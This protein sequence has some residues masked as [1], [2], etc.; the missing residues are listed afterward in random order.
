MDIFQ[1]VER[2]ADIVATLQKFSKCTRIREESLCFVSMATANEKRRQD[3]S[4]CVPFL[5]RVVEEIQAL[6][7]KFDSNY[8]ES[9]ESRRNYIAT[10]KQEELPEENLFCNERKELL[11]KLENYNQALSHKLSI[12]HLNRAETLK[13]ISMLHQPGKT[14]SSSKLEP[15]LRQC[16]CLDSPVISFFEIPAYDCIVE[17]ITGKN[18]S[19][20]NTV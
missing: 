7:T 10:L 14:F 6:L 15:V 20:M 3:L 17:I 11:S 2:C 9:I 19:D 16:I 8:F 5:S 4:L 18:K 13:L 12:L 1:T